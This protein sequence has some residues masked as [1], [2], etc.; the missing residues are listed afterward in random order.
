VEWSRLE[1]EP[2][3]DDDEALEHYRAVAAACRARG[4]EPIVTLHHF[5]N[6]RL[7]DERGGWEEAENLPHLARVARWV[8]AGLAD[9]VDYWITVNEPEVF[10]FYGYASG[11][12]P[13]GVADRSRA[14]A[15]IAN[16][17]EGHA[18][19][20]HALRDVDRIDADG[21]GRATLIGAAKHW[22]LLDPRH[23]WNPFDHLAASVQHRVFNVAV[24]RA[25]AGHPIDL[26][27]PGARPVRRRVDALAGS[28][29]FLGVNFYTRWMVGLF[30][31]DPRWPKR[32]AP[33]NDLGWEIIPE[34]LERA[35]RDCRAFGL[36]MIVTE[37][38]NAD[39][40][41][42]WRP[43]FLRR[44]LASLD[45]ARAEGADVRGY[46]HWSLMDNFEWADGFK[47]RF[48]LHAVDFD[49]PRDRR[50][51]RPSARVYA[52]EVARRRE[53]LSAEG[54]EAR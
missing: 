18:L 14:L 15:V 4:L 34:G 37:S 43:D 17:L 32:G 11:I 26:S 46:L 44:T 50:V 51:P 3:R 48:G 8:G 40:A 42:R 10:G 9:R 52:E 30:G 12:W 28:S 54:R 19:A 29:D 5:T 13:P 23:A 36:P 33:V 22:V 53:G 7:L 47:G 41:D 49:R 20:A 24:V 31:R 45:R 39:A 16:L 6:T 35:L 2:G 25:L 27:I 21:D 1:P 38:G